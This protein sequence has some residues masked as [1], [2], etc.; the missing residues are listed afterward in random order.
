MGAHGDAHTSWMGFYIFFSCIRHACSSCACKCCVSACDSVDSSRSWRCCHTRMVYRES[1]HL[2]QVT[3]YRQHINQLLSKTCI[4][5]SRQATTLE[6]VLV[7][8]NRD[9]NLN[10]HRPRCWWL[11]QHNDLFR[12]MLVQVAGGKSCV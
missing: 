11:V 12:L 6:E 10:L 7:C 1:C 3:V 5:N 4:T 2:P 9:L 8:P